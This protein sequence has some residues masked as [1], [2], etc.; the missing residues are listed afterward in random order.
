MKS[1]QLVALCVGLCRAAVDHD[2]VVYGSSPAGIA[3]AVVAGRQGMKV[4]LYEPLKMIGGMGA[5]GNLALNDGG[6]QAE[7]T[8]LAR[9]FS[10]LNGKHYG[11]NTQ[12]P[13]P[14]SFVAEASF[15]TMLAEAEASF[16]VDCRALSA[17][18][19]SASGVSRIASV[20]LHCEPNPISATV[21]IDASYDGDLMVA[22]GDVEYTAGREAKTQYNES[23]AGARVPGF[24]GVSGPQHVNALRADGTPLKYVQNLSDLAAPGE[25]DDALMAF[26]HR[27]C[28]TNNK[29]I[30]VPWPKPAGYN[31]D[32]FLL[33][34]RAFEANGNK[35]TI[36]FGSHPPG[37][38]SH[39]SKF[40]Q[41]TCCGSCALAGLR[42][43]TWQMKRVVG[44]VLSVRVQTFTCVRAHVCEC[45]GELS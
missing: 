19:S 36:G 33:M 45:F 7:R 16:K 30:L 5:A 21:F 20:S 42:D 2:V 15:K 31:P 39:I 3:A 24:K 28:T 8:G 35:T 40:C 1:T 34:Q 10:Y 4:A 43:V 22:V 9:N 12:V 11:L 25:A 14:E 6:T 32:D 26:Q 37:L 44:V 17:T 29:T 27:L 23:L 13:H 18:K 41:V 38:P